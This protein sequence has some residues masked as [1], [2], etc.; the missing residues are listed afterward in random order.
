MTEETSFEKPIKELFLESCK[1][2]CEQD[3]DDA[4]FFYLTNT[5]HLTL[6]YLRDKRKHDKERLDVTAGNPP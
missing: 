1:M 3:L 5:I 6:N 4:E 2:I